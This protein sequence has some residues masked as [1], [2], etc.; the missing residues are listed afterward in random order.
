MQHHNTCSWVIAHV[1]KDYLY[2]VDRDLQSFA[3]KHIEKP[4]RVQA[5][6]PTI[7]ILRKQFKGRD[8]FETIPLLFNYGFFHLPNNRLQFDFLSKLKSDVPGVHSWIKEDKDES[9]S[10]AVAK[11][12]EIDRIV[13]HH[14]KLSLYDRHDIDNLTPGLLINLR[15]YPFDGMDATIIS[16]DR[17]KEKVKI[18]LSMGAIIKSHEVSFDNILYTVYHDH[19]ANQSQKEVSLDEMKA[20]KKRS[21]DKYF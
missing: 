6:I 13:K 11:S 14:K 8:I 15:G 2:R 5:Y 17:K 1:N 16:V 4:E 3:K 7:K 10:L 18:E 12:T 21:V 20:N 19:D 9:N